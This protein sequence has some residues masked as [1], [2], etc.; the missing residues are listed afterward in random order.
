M[1]YFELNVATPDVS[2]AYR[3]SAKFQI[4]RPLSTREH[5]RSAIVVRGGWYAAYPDSLIFYDSRTGKPTLRMAGCFQSVQRQSSEAGSTHIWAFRDDGTG[6][7]QILSV[8]PQTSKTVATLPTA[9]DSVTRHQDGSLCV[10]TSDRA[11]ISLLSDGTIRQP[12]SKDQ[13]R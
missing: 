11:T 12:C 1:P 8:G 5:L 10:K 9:L 6:G 2:G 4:D 3:P 7:L 13:M